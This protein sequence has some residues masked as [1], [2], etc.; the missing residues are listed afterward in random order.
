MSDGFIIMQIGNKA[1]D[2]VCKDA[3]V[4][5]IKACGLEPKR[6]DKHNQGGLL[7]SEIIDF[8]ERSEIIVADLTNERPNCYLEIGFAMGIDK[9]RNL[10]L[11]ARE[12]H[13]PES[14]NYVK[15]GPKI[16]FDLSGYDILFW[17]TDKLDL[18]RD[19]LEKRIKRRR[20]ILLPSNQAPV[21]PWD[22]EWLKKNRNV[23]VPVLQST[24]KKGF[25]EIRFALN[26]P[27][28]SKTQQELDEAART[29]TV[30]TFGW[31]IGIYMTNVPEY[32]TTPKVDG[33]V[34]QIF[35]RDKK[36]LDY[37]AIRRNGDYYLLKTIFEDE[38]DP[39]KLF[40]DTR[41]IRVT[42]TLIYCAR[43]YSRL[44]V[45]PTSIVNIA[46]KH[47]G[48]K[49]R[50]LDVASPSRMMFREKPCLEDEVESNI[51]T[52]LSG[53]ETNLVELVKQLIAPLF[54]LF[55]FFELDDDTYEEIINAYV[56]GRMP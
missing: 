35:V 6:V 26:Y 41:I 13:N 28:L 15:E 53:L 54:T 17:H 24:E 9:F 10:I 52:S 25:M 39:S 22:N 40:C 30:S 18:F 44:E 5:A 1:L 56:Q 43:L 4:P 37:W 47:G 45:D 31:P 14:S 38:R 2:K 23:A 7:K 19:E 50:I 11:T 48:L 46:I 34:T 29:S 27:K 32:K 8:I 12:D 51:S 20:A 21:S 36:T 42:E 55:D 33:I 49:D 3:I 16:H